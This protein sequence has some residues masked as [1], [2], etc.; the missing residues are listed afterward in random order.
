MNCEI[1]AQLIAEIAS[2]QLA[3]TQPANARQHIAQCYDC[4]AALRGTES[5]ALLKERE[6]GIAPAP[7][8]DSILKGLPTAPA[9]QR[10]R[11]GFWLGTSIGGAVAASILALALTLGWIGPAVDEAPAVAEFTV[12]LGEPRD[13]DI[14]IETDRVLP[15]ATVSILLA[16][17]VELDGYGAR[18]ELSWTVDLNAGINRLTLPVVAVDPAGGRMV[19]RLDHP[20][21][22]QMFVVRLKTEV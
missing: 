6:A 12:A 16:G 18:R 2:G 21:S 4:S 5:L 3:G 7:L 20:D 17:D 22:E 13:M 19:V 15:G 8:F 1:V 11:Q 14:V 10:G 9:K